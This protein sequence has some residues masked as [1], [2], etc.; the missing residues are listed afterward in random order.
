MSLLTTE[1]LLFVSTRNGKGRTLDVNMPRELCSLKFHL[2]VKNF[3]SCHS[4]ESPLCALL[5]C[6]TGPPL[7]WTRRR[8]GA[9]WRFS[10]GM[11]SLQNTFR[12]LG[13]SRRVARQRRWKGLLCWPKVLHATSS[14]WLIS[15]SLLYI[16]LSLQAEV[17]CLCPLQMHWFQLIW[18]VLLV[19]CCHVKAVHHFYNLC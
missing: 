12:S 14:W 8:E 15:T 17:G 18:I 7:I 13:N 19:H 6:L 4:V 10:V 16:D 9:P 5:F 3:L 1:S 2:K 11:T